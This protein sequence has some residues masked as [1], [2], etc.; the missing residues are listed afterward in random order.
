[1]QHRKAGRRVMF[2]SELSHSAWG[3]LAAEDMNERAAAIV[4]RRVACK[5]IAYSRK[6][7]G[8][9]L[10]TAVATAWAAKLVKR[11][12]PLDWLRLIWPGSGVPW[13]P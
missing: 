2:M 13:M 3:A 1:M 4:S 10:T 5:P 11:T 7:T 9:P 12:Q 8:V 6:V